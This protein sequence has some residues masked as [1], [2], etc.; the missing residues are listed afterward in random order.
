M[1]VQELYEYIK[2]YQSI[3]LIYKNITI[4]IDSPTKLK[5]QNAFTRKFHIYKIEEY[6]IQ[7]DANVIC[8][9]NN[10]QQESS[11]V[12]TLTHCTLR[13]LS[14]IGVVQNS[15]ICTTLEDV[16]K[17]IFDVF[18]EYFE[19]QEDF[20]ENY[21]DFIKQFPTYPDAMPLHIVVYDVKENKLTY[22][23]ISDYYSEYVRGICKEDVTGE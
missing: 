4:Q 12:V 14:H 3:D 15:K 9:V 2:N 19:L 7:V 5:I 8:I 20:Y 21:D 17:Y 1:N 10:E 11:Y 23:K 13:T 6:V 22:P 18:D 16:K